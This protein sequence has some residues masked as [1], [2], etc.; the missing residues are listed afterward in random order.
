[1]K[2]ARKADIGAI[3]KTARTKLSLLSEAPEAG[4]GAANL[5]ISP[6]DK[7]PGSRP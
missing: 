5:P 2:A 7:Q 4:G 1:M 3:Q 6:G